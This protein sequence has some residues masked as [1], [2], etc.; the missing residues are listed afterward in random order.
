MVG[1]PHPDHLSVII[2]HGPKY[3]I[4]FYFAKCKGPLFLL[5]ESSNFRREK[6]MRKIEIDILSIP[7]SCSASY[8]QY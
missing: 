1:T 7:L 2:S 5:V 4:L 6:K 8:L 3:Q